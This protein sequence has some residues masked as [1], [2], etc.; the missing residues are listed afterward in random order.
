MFILNRFIFIIIL[1]ASTMLYAQNIADFKWKNRVLL[2]TDSD[3]RLL[4][5]KAAIAPFDALDKEVKE[6]N[7][8]LFMYAKGS[9]Y[10]KNGQQIKL[11]HNLHIPSSFE[12]IVLFG[13]D[14]GIKLQ[15]PY[16]VK[17]A[18]IFNLIDRMPMRRAEMK[19]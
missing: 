2:F 9:F 15:E 7:M 11:Q 4:N 13:K 6:R 8:V 10:H 19:N 1:F 18:T 17:A 14:G 16:P 12:G 5:A 3:Q